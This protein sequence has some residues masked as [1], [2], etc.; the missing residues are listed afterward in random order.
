MR[1]KTS[2]IQTI[3][4]AA[5]NVDGRVILYAGKMTDSLNYA[6]DETK[7]RR[8]KQQ[9]WNEANGITPESVKKDIADILDSVYERADRNVRTGVKGGNL[10]VKT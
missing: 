3:G 8:E 2:L 4:R 10:Q 1:S 9:A 5:R 7:R 6:L